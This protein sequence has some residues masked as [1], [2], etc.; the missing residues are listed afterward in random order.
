MIKNDNWSQI[1]SRIT[2]NLINNFL[3]EFEREKFNKPNDIRFNELMDLESDRGN[4][5]LLRYKFVENHKKRLNVLFSEY[6]L[7]IEYDTYRRKIKDIPKPFKYIDEDNKEQGID[8]LSK[9]DDIKRKKIFSLLIDLDEKLSNYFTKLNNSN[10][11]KKYSDKNIQKL[12]ENL[13]LLFKIT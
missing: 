12:V 2:D 11:L 8:S 6:N 13:N 1:D 9:S 4:D 5:L 3:S 10:D 7:I